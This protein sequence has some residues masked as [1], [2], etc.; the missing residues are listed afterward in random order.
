MT[1]HE[2]PEF[3][4]PR[5]AASPEVELPLAVLSTVNEVAEFFRVHPRTPRRWM[6]EGRLR[7]LKVGGAV[8]IRREEVARFLAGGGQ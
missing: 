3:V 8:R 1:Q 2:A 7:Y 6:A 4:P 5:A